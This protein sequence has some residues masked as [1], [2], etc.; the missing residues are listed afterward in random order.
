MNRAEI[1]AAVGTLALQIA[2]P[3]RPGSPEDTAAKQAATELVVDFLDNVGKIATSLATIATA[4]ELH[5]EWRQEN[6]R[7]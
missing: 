2:N 1:A 4:A 6:W 7:A 3:P 5:A